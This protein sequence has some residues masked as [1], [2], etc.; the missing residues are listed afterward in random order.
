MARMDEN[1]S[2]IIHS[3][4]I[5]NYRRIPGHYTL[6]GRPRDSGLFFSNRF[7]IWQA[8]LQRHCGDTCQIAEQYY[9]YKSNL[10]R[11]FDT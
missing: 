6:S 9:H 4:N 10:A 7:E 5:V 3:V 2:A 1:H 11:G 8:P